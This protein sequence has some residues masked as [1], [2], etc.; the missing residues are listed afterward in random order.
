MNE[1]KDDTDLKKARGKTSLSNDLLAVT[2]ET[3]NALNTDQED[4]LLAALKRQI[5]FNEV[6]IGE[7]LHME[8]ELG[9]LE[10]VFSKQK[11]EQELQKL[12]QCVSK[13]TAKGY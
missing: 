3:P 1:I 10:P 8:N 13:L 12:R 2:C 6:L 5:N 9:K 7:D 11:L 4:R